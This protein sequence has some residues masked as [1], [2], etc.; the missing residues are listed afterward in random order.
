VSRVAVLVVDDEPGMRDTLVAILEQQG[1]VASSA[2]DGEAAVSAVQ[3]ESFDV[4]MMDVRMPKR[5]GVSALEEMGDPPPEV[6]LMTAYALEE[7][8]RA[9]VKAKA[10]AIL[11]KP[12][13]TSRMLSLVAEACPSR[14]VDA[15]PRLDGA[16]SSPVV[17]VVDDDA[18][19]RQTVI[20]ILALAG[21]AAEGFGSGSAA[22]ASCADARPE[23][24]VVDQRLPD[25]T[26]IAL[27]TRL[28]S[29]DPDL[30]VMLLTGF[31]SADNAI[32]AVGLVDDYLTKP[33]PPDD[34]VRSVQAA[35]ERTGLRRENRRLVG[36]L[37]ELNSSLEATVAQRTSELEAAHHRALEMQAIR[38]RLQVQAER[39]RLENRLQQSQ[40]MESLG[41]LAGGVA[42]DFNNLLA[43]ILGCVSFVAEATAGNDS[44]N[45]DV[46][47][48]RTAAEQ[49]AQLTRQ[50]LIFAR[51]E[52]V[53]LEA[54]D[55]GAI[56][57][58][59]QGLLARSIGERVKLVVRGAADL[60]AIRADRGQVEQVLI[61][62]AVNARDAMPDGGTLTIEPGITTLDEEYARRHPEVMPGRY[63]ALSVSD[64][65]MGMSPDVVTRI[66]EPF[67]TTKPVG[68][69]TGLGLATVHGIV[70]AVGGSLSVSSEL[71]AG[72]TIQA[73]FP[74]VEE[75]PTATAAAAASS[76]V[77][78]G[79]ETILVVEDEPGVL[80][81]TARILRGNGYT[82]LAAATGAEA[83]AL[84]ADHE[85]DLLLTDLVMPEITGVQL[86]ERIRQLRPDAAVLFMSGYSQDVLGQ[87]P[88][89]DDS[90][91]LIQKPFTGP[92]LLQ[93]VRAAIRGACPTR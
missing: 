27:A 34:L 91:P 26:G 41:Q 8:L 70:T 6:I 43:V 93:G 56:V 55:L 84:A 25:T 78:G 62:L 16:S 92:A 44:V 2:P 35:L 90:I 63:V 40:R 30:G 59:L 28:K 33:V 81:V 23:L 77:R 38:D 14:Q 64:D 66:F 48:I 9:A 67:F 72:T 37:Q 1:Y 4:V 76:D 21:V 36:R 60:P 31:A 73:F 47:Q 50:L 13:E 17:Y 39:E 69:G 52:H 18:D 85:I 53:Q 75:Q 88:G 10:F 87:Q 58:E 61:N 79:G 15:R 3:K 29:D 82:V 11:H 46:E 12:F 49:A 57:S 86:V 83:Q 54:L 89:L 65:G 71:G 42:H 5:D 51:R 74:V 80:A 24:V 22:Q 19:L 20:E 7:Q 68:K 45:A 32:A